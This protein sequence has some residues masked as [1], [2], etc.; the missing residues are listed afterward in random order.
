[1]I[2]SRAAAGSTA[3]F[4]LSLSALVKATG[5]SPKIPRYIALVILV[6]FGIVMI[7]PM[8]RYRFELWVSGFVSRSKGSRAASQ[9]A[10]PTASAGTLSGYGS[11]IVMG[12]GLGIVWTPCVGP[13]M[14]SVIGLAVGNS[15][16]VGAV[17]ITLAY[18][19]G[20]AIAML[21]VIL[22]GKA[23]IA[24]APWLLIRSDGIQR[25]SAC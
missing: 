14:A 7:L 21:A 4:R 23:L 3:P 6:A 15:A 8:L 12:L 13:I 20:T 22:G 2:R 16:D 10:R 19:V 18:A 25:F 9:Q 1:M 24:Q 5:V 17:V 11:G